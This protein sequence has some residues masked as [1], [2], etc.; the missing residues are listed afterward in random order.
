MPSSL[1]INCSCRILLYIH[2]TFGLVLLPILRV[3]RLTILVL[4]RD[5]PVGD[6]HE[7]YEYLIIRLYSYTSGP[8]AS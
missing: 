4:N 3:F 7:E 1:E 8:D 6:M 5:V 2:S